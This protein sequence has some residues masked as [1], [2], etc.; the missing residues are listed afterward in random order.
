MQ[1]NLEGRPTDRAGARR[2]LVRL[3]AVSGARLRCPRQGDI[4]IDGC[5][6]CP[7]A[8]LDE[9]PSADSFACSYPYPAADTFTARSRR[10]E[11]VRLALSQT[12]ERC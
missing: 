10:R 9:G 8:C 4:D 7:F 12:L 6:G 1:R 3:L 11:D 5:A 2:P